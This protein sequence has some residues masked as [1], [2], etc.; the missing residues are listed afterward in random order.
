MNPK[1]A[2]WLVWLLFKLPLIRNIVRTR[3][4]QVEIGIRH[5]IGEMSDEGINDAISNIKDGGYDWSKEPYVSL[6]A[7]CDHAGISFE[8]ILQWL[9][10][11]KFL[12]EYRVE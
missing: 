1:F 9:E 7:I 10:D 8:V 4:T 11:E 12:R 5:S 3:S 6:K 2:S